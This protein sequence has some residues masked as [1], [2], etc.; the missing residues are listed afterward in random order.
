M[1]LTTLDGR[2]QLVERIAS[3]GMGEVYLAHDV[4][5]A[6]DVAI[7]VLHRSLAG[8][9]GFVERFRTEARSA[10]GLNHPNIVSVYDWGAVD[11]VYFMVMEHIEGRSVR[12]LLQPLGHLEP[13]Q[14]ADLVLQ[15]LAALEHAH[16]KGIV[17]R[18]LKPE[19]IL[20]NRRGVAKLADFGLARAY[21]DGHI[22]QAPGT[23]TGTVQYLAPEQIRGE[24]A[25]PR[26][27][28]YSLGIVTFELLT[29]R[30]PFSGETS[31]AI[32]YKHLSERVPRPS[33]LVP[34]LPRELDGF[35][36]SATERDRELRPESAAEMR[37]D[38]EKEAATL[39]PAR[40][41]AELVEDASVLIADED[42]ASPEQA[43][44]VTIPR[45]ETRKQVRGRRWR[46]TF[47]LLFGLLFLAGGAWAAWTYL[48][49]HAI[50]VPDVLGMPAANA[51]AR[52]VEEGL[53]VRVGRSVYSL[54]YET[55]T[56]AG[57]TPAVGTGV[58]KGA[59]ITLITSLGP[60][61]VALPELQGKT[62]DEASAALEAAGFT[63]G[64][65]Q[66]AFHDKIPA[67]SVIRALVAGDTAP[68]GS[69][70]GLLISKGPPPVPVPDVVGKDVGA[71]KKQLAGMGFHVKIKTK[72]SKSVPRDV[73]ISQKPDPEQKLAKGSSVRITVS[74]GPKTF[75]VGTFLGLTRDAAVTA[76]Q[77]A[78][79]KANIVVVP[80][81]IDDIVRGQDP[82]PGSIVHAG[83]TITIYI[84]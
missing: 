45:A 33:A 38:L 57:L 43:T 76:I 65:P 7:K 13:A 2:Y 74:L 48:V 8:D 41:L 36:A 28:L 79:L 70:V 3:G 47:G 25:D 35:V 60:R 32:A 77:N 58:D 17:H 62:L 16:A 18:D 64:N 19:N 63:V 56:V 68:E 73:V 39:P 55:G 14:V 40:S 15:A 82:T 24:P 66:R 12:E 75:A 71:A 67:G 22:T 80:G 83:D 69:A 53:T 81:S 23:V 1:S 21:M 61:P 84:G 49:P 10:A 37:R 4:V 46:R 51:R 59:R 34:H 11:G 54:K 50:T 20:V 29:G 31:I 52:L 5:L 72:Y 30:V 26:T 9:A 78:G 42:D 6:R 44:T 27:D